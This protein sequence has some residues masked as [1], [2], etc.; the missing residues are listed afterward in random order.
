[1]NTTW[2]PAG[3]PYI[4]TG[5]VVVRHSNA[6]TDASKYATLTLDPGVTVRFSP[7]TGLTIGKPYYPDKPS[8]QWGY[9]GALAVQGTADAPVTFTSNEIAPAP[10]DWNGIHFVHYTRD[11]ASIVNHAVVEYGGLS[12]DAN[13]HCYRA[14]PTLQNSVIRH[15][16]GHGVIASVSS[17]RITGCR[18]RDNAKSGVA[19]S[20]A[21]N[22]I[23]GAAGEGNTITLN[24]EYGVYAVDGTPDPLIR[25]NTITHNGSY[26]IRIGADMR[27]S[28]NTLHGNGVEAIE[29]VTEDVASN[30]TW[31]NDASTYMVSGEIS[32]GHTGISADGS[33]SVT[34]T[35]EPGVT[36]AFAAGAGLTIGKPYYS[37]KPWDTF[38]Y[39]GA[40]SAQGSA[41]SPVVFT[42]ASAAPA[43]G[44]WK[45]IYF[46]NQTND[47]ATVFE[48]CIVEYGGFE[49]QGAL[50]I[51]RSSPSI[52]NILVRR[53]SSNGIH[54]AAA[55][56]TIK[57]CTVSHNNGSGISMVSTSNPIIGAESEGNVIT[58]NAEHGVSATDA[59]P[60]PRIRYNTIANNG[61]YP[62]RTGAR[63][64]VD[65]SAIVGNGVQA[66]YVFAEDI[67]TDVLWSNDA[68]AYIIDGDITVWHTGS[69]SNA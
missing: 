10:G 1:Q 21:S 26:P 5:D 22:P 20:S 67:R 66:V 69:S 33:K 53:S 27:V 41:E 32:V 9:F 19:L 37:D 13:I 23:I 51:Y 60:L 40:I 17:P 48:H 12:K 57:S 6:S 11:D 42:S 31:S 8:D 68:P 52:Q 56:P 58:D 44:D 35:I 2:T 64:I 62:I 14:A 63:M 55:S 15:S 30:T 4:V 29:V 7:G 18:I 50:H 59:A 46:Q 38:G 65:H 28:D 61:G 43:A 39:Y 16:S 54:L 3:S 36:V 49:R 34:L 47:G 25:C 45:G 24:G